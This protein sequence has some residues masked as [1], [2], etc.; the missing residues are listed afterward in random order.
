[1]RRL[2]IDDLEDLCRRRGCQWSDLFLVGNSVFVDTGPRDS[3]IPLSWVPLLVD[4][5]EVAAALPEILGRLDARTYASLEHIRAEHARSAIYRKL[6]DAISAI[7]ESHGFT[8]SV[9]DTVQLQMDDCGGTTQFV[10][11][12]KAADATPGL[13]VDLRGA[14]AGLPA[15]WEIQLHIANDNGL[16]S[17]SFCT[18]SQ[19]GVKNVG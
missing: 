14:L 16:D 8:G 11:L 17:Q 13:L 9:E 19:E 3:H 10:S 6:N 2:S 18:I 12:A 7:L 1:M 5:L 4:N 15:E